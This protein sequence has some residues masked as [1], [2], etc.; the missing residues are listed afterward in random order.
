MAKVRFIVKGSK[1]IVQLIVRVSVTRQND[2]QKA[3][4][5]FIPIEYW[6]KNEKRLYT[7]EDKTSLKNDADF[8]RT[9]NK[10]KNLLNS[11]E[12][13]IFN[14]LHNTDIISPNFIEDEILRFHSLPTSIEQK[15]KEVIEKD[16]AEE[17][18]SNKLLNY[19]VRY[20]KFRSNDYS[21]KNSTKQK[22]IYAEKIINEFE[23]FYKR[24]ILLNECDKEFFA[25]F[26]TF[27]FNEKKLMKSTII[28][29]I[30]NLKTILF[31][32]QNN[33]YKINPQFSLP[34]KNSKEGDV[35]YLTLEELN[36]IKSYKTNDKLLDIT[37]DWLIVGCFTGQRVSDFMK[38][39][40]N[41]IRKYKDKNENEF[42][43]I[44]I[45]QIKTKKRVTIPLHP[46]VKNIINKYN[47]F[48]PV[49]S[50]NSGSN[51]TIFN[52]NLKKLLNNA[53]INRMVYAKEY[54]VDD[55]RNYVK[56]IPLYKAASSHICRRSFASNYYG[57]PNFP[58]SLLIS[59]TGHQFESTFL[60]YIGKNDIS[61]ALEIAKIFNS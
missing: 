25:T 29:V 40:K 8:I 12:N 49:F 7:R 17:I 26:D 6:N 36:L 51:S 21:I 13:I 48:P 31:D 60:E 9:V 16:K 22:Y 55:K 28:R 47:D 39:N 19:I 34:K 44:E 42:E 57:H 32:A 56:L 37:K 5:I 24:E 27:L 46:V 30:K 1:D 4:R 14:Y 18:N 10:C 61:K 33:G 41:C 50:K 52:V 53:E 11:I 54:D 59:I 38:F 23:L 45:T 2:F 20:N 43:L 35:I 15:E 3:S 58:T